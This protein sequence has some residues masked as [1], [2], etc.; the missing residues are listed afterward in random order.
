MTSSTSTNKTIDK[1]HSSDEYIPSTQSSDEFLTDKVRLQK[2]AVE[3]RL[4]RI[5]SKPKS[6]IGVLE[7]A[8][9]VINILAEESKLK[10]ENIC[11]T[12]EKIK[13]DLPFNILADEY[14][15]SLSNA[16]TIYRKT[17]PVLAHFLKRFVF[18]PS[19]E[20]IKSSLPLSFRARYNKVQS[21]IDC[22]EIQIQKPTNPMHQALS[23]SDYKK[24]N[25]VKYLISSTP[26][27]TI[28]FISQSF[29]GRASDVLIV[30]ESNYIE[31]LPNDCAVMADRRFKHIEPL[32]K[33]KNCTLVRP[34]S[35]SSNKKPSKYEVMETKCI[36]S[37]R[38]YIERVIKRYREFSF[39]KPHATVPIQSLDLI[40]DV[41]I[42]ISAL[43]NLQSPVIAQM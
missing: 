40:D 7:E 20:T 31:Q 39:L 22:F 11:L 21:I 3:F 41:I 19:S 12:L 29:G 42:I 8:F 34:P 23:W 30:E 32:L 6:Y 26:D 15:M 9:F 24:C 2:Q 5:S 10:F 18:W 28:N 14:G 37:L 1:M 36:A 38:I 25:T 4:M 43:I 13:L 27:G 33:Q 16:N 17:V 35:V